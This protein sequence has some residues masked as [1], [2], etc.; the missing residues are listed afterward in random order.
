MGPPNLWITINISDLHDP[1]AQIFVGENINLDDF[2][3]T[4]GPDAEHWARNIAADPYASAKFFHFLICTILKKL[5]RVKVTNYQMKSK[6]GILGHVSAYFG[7]IEL[8]G[9]GTLHLHLLIWLKDV[10][11]ADEMAE[12][13]QKEDFHAKIHWN[14]S[15]S[16]PS[17]P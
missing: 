16:I 1:I 10:L 14:Q 11:N 15:P 9:W 2:L 5:I 17:R 6:M 4:L 8:Q 3:D 7:T 12:L 13:L